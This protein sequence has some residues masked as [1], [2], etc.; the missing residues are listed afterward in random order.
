[1]GDHMLDWVGAIAVVGLGLYPMVNASIVIASGRRRMGQEPFEDLVSILF[2]SLGQ[3]ALVLVVA[4]L[5]PR[6]LSSIGIRLNLGVEN[7]TSIVWTLFALEGILIVWTIGL[8][9]AFKCLKRPLDEVASSPAQSDIYKTGLERLAYMLALLWSVAAEDLVFRGY[10]VLYLGLRTGAYWPWVLV[11]ISL[12]VLAHL[13]QGRSVQLIAGHALIAATMIGLVLWSGNLIALIGA[14]Y[15]LDGMLIF[16]RW[17]QV[18]PVPVEVPIKDRGAV[19]QGRFAVLS[20]LGAGLA[21][22]LSLLM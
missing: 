20:L 7:W 10:L 2:T 12:S 13:Y 9:M 14:H 21:I 8:R 17:H 6:G 4:G 16:R 19:P 18:R 3:T 22:G 15:L 11:S 5:D 1:M